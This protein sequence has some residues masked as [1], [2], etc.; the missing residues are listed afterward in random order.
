MEDSVIGKAS[1]AL[2]ALATIG[3]TQPASAQNNTV[4]GALFGGAPG[5]I[6]GGAATGSAGGAVA[7]A[8]IGGTPP[9]PKPTA[10]AAI[11]GGAAAAI[12]PFRAATCGFRIA[13]ATRAQVSGFPDACHFPDS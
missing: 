13:T 7:G 12:R 8:L 9:E 1:V 5:G 3:L 6:I 2:F 11:I 4:G 10:A